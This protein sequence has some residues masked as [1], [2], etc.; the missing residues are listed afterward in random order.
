M[1]SRR[2]WANHQWWNN[3]AM[4]NIVPKEKLERREKRKKLGNYFLST[5]ISFFLL[6]DEL[7]TLATTPL[8]I[9]KQ[10]VSELKRLI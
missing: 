7:E 1:L 6:N 5:S 2:C 4:E 9:S 8:V 10:L 3:Y